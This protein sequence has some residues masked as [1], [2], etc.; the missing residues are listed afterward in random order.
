MWFFAY[1]NI[2][3]LFFISNL[4]YNNFIL[5]IAKP[6]GKI[7]RLKTV[8]YFLFPAIVIG[9]IVFSLSITFTMQKNVK[10]IMLKN[11]SNNILSDSMKLLDQ[12]QN[13][14]DSIVVTLSHDSNIQKLVFE[15][16]RNRLYEYLKEYFN[17]MKDNF[18]INALKFYSADLQPF[19]D[20]GNFD[21]DQ[22]IDF[23]W[24]QKIKS[25]FKNNK[26]FD[27]IK[28][29]GKDLSIVSVYPI[30]YKGKFA[31]D[32][33]IGI[34]FTSESLKTFSGD[35]IVYIPF[36]S[37]RNKID[38]YILENDNFSS[39]FDEKK[40]SELDSSKKFIS[41]EKGSFLYVGIPLKDTDGN[42]LGYLFNK[43]NISNITSIFASVKGILI[44]AYLIIIILSVAL[45]AFMGYKILKVINKI[46]GFSS[47]LSKNNFVIDFESKSKDELSLSAASLIKS[48]TSLRES[49][50]NII[51]VMKG[52]IISS[53]AI[54]TLL[55]SEEKEINSIS[56]QVDLAKEA[57]DSIVSAMGEINSGI[58]NINIG[59][60]TV[61]ETAQ[62]ILSLTDELDKSTRNSRDTISNVSEDMS[63]LHSISSDFVITVDELLEK[64]DNIGEIVNTISSITEQTNLLALNAAIEAARAGEAGRGFSVVA[65]EIRQLAEES[66]KATG[67]IA[68]ILN[69]LKEN[70]LKVNVKTKDINSKVDE[71]NGKMKNVYDQIEKI[72]NE[73]GGISNQMSS[74]TNISHE[75]STSTE[76]M[77]MVMDG[78]AGKIS[79]LSQSFAQIY[80]NVY[81]I[82]NEFSGILNRSRDM[83]KVS[84]DNYVKTN[85]TFKLFDN[86]DLI[87][88]FEG[89]KKAHLNYLKKVKK[90]LETKEF[91][92]VETDPHFCNFGIFYYSYTPDDSYIKEWK[93]VES[94]HSN[95]HILTRKLIDFIKVNKM[96]E[97][98]EL[99]NTII[100]NKNKLFSLLDA[101]IE[102][103]KN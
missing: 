58:E 67:N 70:V 20:L 16:N 71:S 83:E 49:I 42:I 68:E 3:N 89:A 79:E 34:I 21:N 62:N 98:N 76:K 28:L 33:E 47:K 10:K 60:N 101:I 13:R 88:F 64:A 65:D 31:G 8:F 26:P 56:D 75:Q 19:L 91:I 36:D 81:N 100:K 14:L 74:L 85:S 103:L 63:N 44:T 59:A 55:D 86:E 102:K 40:L 41:F 18:S 25:A 4:L 43:T 5:C 29:S 46:Q 73:V 23:N 78:A 92:P 22:K 17:E 90:M 84:F 35:N 11:E 95:V 9:I 1:A 99:Y 77:S 69:D 48:I 2:K 45:F 52:N 30:F 72:A 54:E 38:K 51:G 39:V 57:I 7:M 24:E 37:D 12:Y 50:I 32:F 82:K 97:A 6:R 80:T 66:K 93:D 27:N 87:K 15:K 53:R 94:Y 61:S 96:D